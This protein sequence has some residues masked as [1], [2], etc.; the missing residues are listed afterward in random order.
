MAVDGGPM[1]EVLDPHPTVVDRQL[2]WR[3]STQPQFE[4]I[5]SP[6][7]RRSVVHRR[8]Q[9]GDALTDS[10]HVDEPGRAAGP[11]QLRTVVVV[12]DDEDRSEGQRRGMRCDCL[13]YTSD[14]A[15]E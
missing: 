3:G 4:P 2:E 9:G 5:V 10:R 11:R 8:D 12:I 15:D 7:G 13:L 14:A 6:R 1:V